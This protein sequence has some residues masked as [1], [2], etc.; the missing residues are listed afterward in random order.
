M[1]VMRAILVVFLL[2]AANYDAAQGCC[3]PGEDTCVAVCLTNSG[4]IACPV[5]PS[6][7]DASSGIYVP[8]P[9]FR[10]RV[11][12]AEG[13]APSPD[14]PPPRRSIRTF[15]TEISIGQTI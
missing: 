14:P 5:L 2:V 11:A 6:E 9:A 4:C 7:V 10:A 12:V 3:T 13:E 8:V 1:P 15:N